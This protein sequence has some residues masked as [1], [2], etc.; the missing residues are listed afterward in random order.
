MIWR[1]AEIYVFD[2]KLVRPVVQEER[3]ADRQKT[4]IIKLVPVERA[5][6]RNDL[7]DWIDW[8]KYYQQKKSFMRIKPPDDVVDAML[9]RAD[10]SRFRKV[11][12]GRRAEFSDTGC[13]GAN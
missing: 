8:R 4:K 2:G 7:S 6:L 1:G 5:I 12:G 9:W 10:R 3:A 13:C 11:S